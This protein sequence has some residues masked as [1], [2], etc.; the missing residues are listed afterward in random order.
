MSALADDRLWC[1]LDSADGTRALD[2]IAIEGVPGADVQGSGAQAIAGATLMQRA[3][4]AAFDLLRQRWPDAQRLLV[5]CGGGNNG[6]DGYVVARLAADAGLAPVILPLVPLDALKGDAL[7]MA[8]R[9]AD[10]PHIALTELP[11][12]LH[13][14]DL[15]VDALLGTGL[16]TPVREPVAGLIDAL[17]ASGKPSLALDLPSGLHADTG[18]P[19]GV[20][21]R[22]S[23]TITFIGVKTGLLTGAGPD[24]CGAL[25]FDDLDVPAAVY[26]A[27][28]PAALC[29]RPAL[30]S[31][32]LPRRLRAGHK[33]LYGHVLVIGGDQGYAGAA[34]MAAQAALR[35]GAGL[36]SVATRAEHVSGFLTRQPELMVP[37]TETRAALD[38]LLAKASVLVVGPG[39]G[40]GAWGRTMLAA[41]V[42]AGLPMVLDA[43]AINLLAAQDLPRR[44]NAVWTPHPGEAA[45]MLDYSTAAIQQ[46]RFAALRKL[47]AATGGAVLLKGVGTLISASVGASGDALPPV[48]IQRG[49][50]GM[51]TGGMGDV[52]SGIIG[53]LLGQGLM[54]RDAAAVG[55]L[56]HAMAADRCTASAGERGLLATDLLAQLPALVNGIGLYEAA[57]RDA[58]HD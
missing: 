39:L 28:P 41:A 19:L 1:R 44:A 13:D 24:H 31:E 29:P 7:T 34:M 5:C 15:I 33:G 43:D 30:I 51:A 2:R 50:P 3:G 55:A 52:L 49:N 38:T 17:N 37:G 46:D 22:A 58:A 36:V 12:A 16:S 6:G 47:T 54:P 20:A 57:H 42:D 35:C 21:V 18:N 40:Q 10:V 4:Q 53:A 9:A 45:R 23:A 11:A 56:V 14:T 25:H 32:M 8:E 26:A 48:L 27:V